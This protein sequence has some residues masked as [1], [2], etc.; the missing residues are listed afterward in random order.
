VAPKLLGDAARGMFS[1]PGVE[2]LDQALM[3][4]IEDVRA[5]GD[6]WRIVAR[7]SSAE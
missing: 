6:D 5:V 7:L 1:L 3:P 4:A 2:R